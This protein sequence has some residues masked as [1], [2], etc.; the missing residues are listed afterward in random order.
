MFLL[1]AALSLF[2]ALATVSFKAL[3][4]ATANPAK[5]LRYE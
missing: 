1:A 2:I 5:A 3:K 4:T